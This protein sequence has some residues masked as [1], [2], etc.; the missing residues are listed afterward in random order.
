MAKFDH[1]RLM[2]LMREKKYS[3]ERLA[4]EMGISEAALWNKLHNKSDFT[5]TEM[6]TVMKVLEIEN[7]MRYFFDI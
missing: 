7:P 6:F 1:S 3:Q 5:D 2:G 4:K